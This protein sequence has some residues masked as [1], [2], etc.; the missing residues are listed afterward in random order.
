MIM[1]VWSQYVRLHVRV[2]LHV[3]VGTRCVEEKS[4]GVKEQ[5]FLTL[6]VKFM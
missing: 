5:V 3:R 2:C 4:I 1:V 6:G